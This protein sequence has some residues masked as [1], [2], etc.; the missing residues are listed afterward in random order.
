MA[1]LAM[2]VV[3]VDRRLKQ[4][5]CKYKAGLHIK[6]LPHQKGKKEMLGWRYDS[7]VWLVALAVPPQDHSLAPRTYPAA[8]NPHVTPTPGDLAPV[9]ISRDT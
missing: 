2:H 7:P 8:L 4:E 5:S 1:G 9:L 3:T 6:I